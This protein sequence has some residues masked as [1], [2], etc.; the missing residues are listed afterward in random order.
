MCNHYTHLTENVAGS[1]MT[2]EEHE[3]LALDDGKKWVS[4]IKK[5]KD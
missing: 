3:K 2:R 1:V 5:Q 4:L